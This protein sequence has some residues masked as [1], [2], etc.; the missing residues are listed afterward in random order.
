M[1]CFLHTAALTLLI[2]D[3]IS[4]P[5]TTSHAAIPRLCRPFPSASEQPLTSEACSSVMNDEHPPHPSRHSKRKMLPSSFPQLPLPDRLRT[6]LKLACT[7]PSPQPW[8]TRNLSALAFCSGGK[9]QALRN[10]TSGASPG[11]TSTPRS[12][13]RAQRANLQVRVCGALSTW[14]AMVS[15]SVSHAWTGIVA[16]RPVCCR[17]ADA[18]VYSVKTAERIERR[19]RSVGRRMFD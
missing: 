16:Q 5:V 9:S 19:Y 17:S 3:R 2:E 12:T 11:E 14:Y 13:S 8:H 4:A 15:T 6:S 1:F 10:R 18:A 7:F